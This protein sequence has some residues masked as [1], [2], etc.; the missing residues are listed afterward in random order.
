MKSAKAIF[1]K[2]SEETE[3]EMLP[4][5]V[6][7]ILM[8]S[9]SFFGGTQL[10]GRIDKYFIIASIALLQTFLVLVGMYIMKLPKT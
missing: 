7:V 3:G 10:R 9:V 8:A 6:L 1:N 2:E 5:I 4:L